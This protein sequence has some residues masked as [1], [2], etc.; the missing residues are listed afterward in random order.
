MERGR[1]TKGWVVGL[2][3]K[4]QEHRRFGKLA[5]AKILR[6]QDDDDDDDERVVLMFPNWLEIHRPYE[7]VAAALMR[8]ALN[9]A[10]ERR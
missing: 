5:P 4:L 6:V 1:D 2:S 3:I 8:E 9:K 10:K 7:Q